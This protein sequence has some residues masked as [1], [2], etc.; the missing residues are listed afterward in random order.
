MTEFE[1]YESIHS[2]SLET[3][4]DC[5]KDTIYRVIHAVTI[6]CKKEPKTL[7]SLAGRNTD[8]MSRAE[9]EEK[10][11][12]IKRKPKFSREAPGGEVV[13]PSGKRPSWRPDMETADLALNSY[14]SEETKKYV[15]EGKRAIGK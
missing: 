8:K 1:I 5:G 3:C 11:A 7:G 4:P 14:T 6:N 13:E 2:N 10:A 15:L 12:A 9:R